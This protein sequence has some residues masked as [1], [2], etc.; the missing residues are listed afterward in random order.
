M[1]TLFS[2]IA[3]ASLIAPD[4]SFPA[5]C[6]GIHN[7]AEDGGLANVKALPR[8]YPYPVFKEDNGAK[9]P[10]DFAMQAGQKDVTQLLR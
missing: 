7:T 6:R 8:G 3:A 5:L 4:Y 1:H 9:A 10:L 2:R